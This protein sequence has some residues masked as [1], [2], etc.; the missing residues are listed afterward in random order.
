MNHPTP[1]STIRWIRC[2]R[3]AAGYAATRRWCPAARSTRARSR[4]RSD[5]LVYTTELLTEDLEVTGPISLTLYASSSAPDT[6]FTAKLVDVDECGCLRAQSDRRHHPRPLPRIA[7]AAATAHPGQGL[8]IH[9]RSCGRRPTSSRRDIGSDW[10]SRSSNFPALRPQSQHRPRP[11]RRRRN[12]SRAA[13][14]D[15]SERDGV[16]PD[17]AGNPRVAISGAAPIW[18]LCGPCRS[19]QAQSPQTPCR[20]DAAQDFFLCSL[21]SCSCGTVD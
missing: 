3:G 6:D 17:A 11:V 9:H 8:R 18:Q 10:R 7:L 12:P 21:P 20:R 2:P 16:V 19:Y 1:S 15:A 13:N 5:V 14:R 4:A